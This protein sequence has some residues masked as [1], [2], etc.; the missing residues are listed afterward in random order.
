MIALTE[1]FPLAGAGAGPAPP[2]FTLDGDACLEGHLAQACARVLGG[3]R[4]L[5]PG[6]KLEAVLLG[7]GYGRGEGGVLRDEKGD[8]PYNDLEFY[9]AIAGR[10][11]FNEFLYE[12]R[13]Q[14]LGEILTPLAGVEVEFKITSLAEIARR[15]I[16]MF[17]Y[18]L[19]VGHRWL[20]GG[21]RSAVAE[22]W[23]HHR[24][25]GNIPLEE[26]TRLMMN[27]CS[28]LLFAR[29]RLLQEPVTPV[30]VDFARRNIAKAQLAM[31]DAVLAAHRLYHW[32]CRERHRRLER[33]AR[34]ETSPWWGELLR[35]HAAGVEFKLHPTTRAAAGETLGVLHDGVTALARD[36][37]LWLEARRLG[38]PFDSVRAYALDAR[39][40]GHRS[41][42]GRNFLLNF[43]ADGFRLRLRAKPWRHP[44]QRIFRALALLLWEPAAL[45]DPCLR[46]RLQL[47][48]NV[49][50][51]SLPEADA[52][53]A[54]L[55]PRL[56]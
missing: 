21:R 35:H 29:A 9:V 28:G 23:K 40:Q 37:W 56:R 43:R 47:D 31:G 27:R 8:R 19:A 15:P 4:G 54:A 7:G 12:R 5:I 30:T 34:S 10:R 50:V 20:W 11:H 36:C 14:V 26:A 13:L 41:S 32:S 22:G 18:D 24:C 53:Y 46:E 49:P 3:I 6:R 52:A 1:V 45:S 42:R 25:P 48:L 16:S 38:R 44:R 51:A 33:L 2:R 39:D 17:S 55:W